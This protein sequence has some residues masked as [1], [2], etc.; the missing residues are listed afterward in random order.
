MSG[1]TVRRR[2]VKR[3]L[4]LVLALGFAMGLG[5]PLFSVAGRG[6][7]AWLRALATRIDRPVGAAALAGRPLQQAT[8]GDPPAVPTPA[9]DRVWRLSLRAF[10]D[11]VGKSAYACTGCDGV[12]SGSD[13]AAA[14]STPLE[15]LLVAVL[16]PADDT[17]VLWTGRLKRANASQADLSA[18]VLLTQAP[19]YEV[20]LI[21]TSPRGYTLCPNSPSS[22]YLDQVDFDAA[23]G[24]APDTGRNLSQEWY[25]WSC[26]IEQR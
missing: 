12:F 21:D 22:V 13:A 11:T 2:G 6:P 25:F 9:Q 20:R 14:A 26:R 17:Q 1:K 16:D 15:P 8:P 7:S 10:P 18:L 24:G 19:P 23:V 3:S 5:S 4:L